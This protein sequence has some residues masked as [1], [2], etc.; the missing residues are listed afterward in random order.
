MD[1][2]LGDVDRLVIRFR[3]GDA[4]AGNELVEAMRYRIA[5]IVGKLRYVYCLPVDAVDDLMQLGQLGMLEAVGRFVPE[6]GSFTT[7]AYYVIYKSCQRW[8]E[9]QA[10]ERHSTPIAAV[11][12]PATET[13]PAIIDADLMAMVVQQIGTLTPLQ[14]KCIKAKFGIGCPVRS[15]QQYA[16]ELGVRKQSVNAAIQRGIATLK[17]QFEAM[18]GGRATTNGITS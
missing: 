12:P 6:K 14:Q 11:D 4:A 2:F 17:A 7:Y 9:E 8:C 1:L 3:E 10:Q 18:E 16:E 15:S 5:S 13:E